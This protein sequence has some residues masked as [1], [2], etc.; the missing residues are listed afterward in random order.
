MIPCTIG[1]VKLEMLVDSGADANLISDAMWTSLKNKRIIVKSSTKGSNK[2]L[3]SYGRDDPLIILGTFWANIA[4]G[5]R[6]V[7]AEFLV[8]EGGQKCLLGDKT[9]KDL[10]VLRVGLEVNQLGESSRP[11][12]KISGVQA[13]I[14]I[15]PD[16]VPVFQ[17]M[18]RI[19]LPLEAAVHRKLEEMI[20]RDIIEEKKGPTTWVSPLVVVGKANGE[21]RLCLDLRRVNENIIREHHPMPVVD[22]YLARLGR[23]KIW[24][25]LDI[26]E[27]FLQ[28]EL[29]E[30]SKDITTFITPKGLFRFKRLCFGLATAPE[31]FQKAMDEIL[32]GCPGTY[33]YLD[34]II[35]EG[36]DLKE[37]DDRLQEVQ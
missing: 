23:G 6:K 1:G 3:R 5:N 29:S 11:F 31:L 7:D 10:G 30:D 8:V 37:H 27:A 16:A 14:R 2:I 21:P 22:D 28:I 36:G 12:T 18:R 9:A 34:D 33:W 13:K 25:K 17:P 19:P 15:K 4:V 24:S 32:S 26:R 35:I 20:K